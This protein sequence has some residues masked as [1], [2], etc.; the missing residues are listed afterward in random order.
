MCIHSGT[1]LCSGCSHVTAA[2]YG[3]TKWSV[4]LFHYP[5]RRSFLIVC[6]QL[7]TSSKL[8]LQSCFFCG[9]E[10]GGSFIAPHS[11]FFSFIF[12]LLVSIFF[13]L[14]CSC[15]LTLAFSLSLYACPPFFQKPSQ[16]LLTIAVLPTWEFCAFA[17][18]FSHIADKLFALMWVSAN[19]IVYLVLV[20]RELHCLNVMKRNP[21]GW[22]RNC[23]F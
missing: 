18:M 22:L 1:S 15:S 9:W 4:Y 12:L 14:N 7:H 17:I 23:N 10:G 5:D 21:G 16:P 3:Q 19:R 20:L 11:M 13:S 2:W 8:T 6:K